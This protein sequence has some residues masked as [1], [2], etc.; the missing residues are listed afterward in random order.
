LDVVDTSDI[1]AN[2]L[3]ALVTLLLHASHFQQRGWW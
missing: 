2:R 1:S 3:T